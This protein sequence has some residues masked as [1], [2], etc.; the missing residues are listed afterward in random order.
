M[1]VNDKGNGII[2]HGIGGAGKS[3]TAAQYAWQE[4][5][6]YDCMYWLDMETEDTLKQCLSQYQIREAGADPIDIVK[7]LLIVQAKTG[8]KGDKFR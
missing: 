5:D 2:L 7:E 3:T 4:K 8:N 6:K 1:D